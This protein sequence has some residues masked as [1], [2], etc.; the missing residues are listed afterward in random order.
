MKIARNGDAQAQL[1][2]GRLYLSG[3]EGLAAND[4][5]A[6]HWL[7]LAAREGVPEADELIA[8]SVAEDRAGS[9]VQRYIEPCERA[10][11]RGH[12]AGHCA[13]GDIYAARADAGVDS[14]K[15]KAQY[16]AAAQAGHAPAARK[17]GLMLVQDAR[18]ETAGAAKEAAHWLQQAAAAGDRSAARNLGQLLWRNGDLE[19]VRWLEPE[20]E[21][22]DLDAMYRLGETLCA[23][24]AVA[25][26]R[27]GVYWLERAARQGHALALWRYG[28]LH[29]KSFSTGP[30]GLPHSPLQ[31][32]RLLERAAG[33]GA[34]AAFWDLARIYEMP[35]FSRRNLGTARQYLEQA[36]GAGI[37]EAELELGQRLSRHK[38]DRAAW[39]AAG[40]WLSSAAAK[41]SSAAIALRARIADSAPDWTPAALGRQEE[42]L[43]SI[44]DVQPLVAARLELAA[45]FG[46]SPREM[47]FI[48]PL[49]VDR[50]WCIEVDLSAHFKRTPWR[51]VIIETEAQRRALA[52]ACG[53]F[54]PADNAD[55]DLSGLSTTGR[56][57]QL[58]AA[59]LRLRA[60]PALF[61]RGWVA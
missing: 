40:R 32:C 35:R 23:Q 54:L 24:S 46:L 6:L 1:S 47:L 29:I 50:E 55:F 44:R 58:K 27:R 11:A 18:S 48:N 60:D 5:A 10:A 17:L 21:V 43:Q 14:G 42:I 45:R 3:G 4:S 38:N 61:V 7:S 26:V 53:A 12:A 30:T 20:A 59:C 51:L 16:R 33:A 25:Q 13:L 52:R 15:A 41:G 19:A 2:L 34:S 28:R 31:A 57:R 56:A 49:E 39:L 8:D 36:A 22:G 9:E 37:C